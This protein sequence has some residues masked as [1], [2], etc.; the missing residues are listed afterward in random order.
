MNGEPVQPV[1]SYILVTRNKLPYLQEVMPRLLAK[2]EPDDEVVVVDGKSTDGTA[3]YLADLYSRGK[4]SAFLSEPDKSEG[5]AF[6]KALLMSKGQLLKAVSDDD[7]F[8]WPSI[9]AAKTFMLDHPDIDFLSGGI[10]YTALFQGNRT[11]VP[12]DQYSNDYKIWLSTGQAFPFCGL[13]LLIRKSSLPLLGL[14]HTGCLMPDYEYALRATSVGN[15]AWH[16]AMCAVRVYN[17][18]SN[19]GRKE[20]ERELERW[21]LFAMYKYDP[22]ARRKLLFAKLMWSAL[23]SDLRARWW[24]SPT[25]ESFSRD[26]IHEFYETMD[27]QL[28][29]LNEKDPGRILYRGMPEN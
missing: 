24:Q 26:F 5:H 10:G 13:A 25:K 7:L 20:V 8:H 23:L 1:M 27:R 18:G 21:R 9:R 17:P 29:A 22:P 16:T 19:S 12:A 2:V 28:L 4:I 6:N 14:L 3:E 11:I 15:L